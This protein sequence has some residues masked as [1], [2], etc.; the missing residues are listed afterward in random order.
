MYGYIYKTT[1]LINGKIY[2]GQHKSKVFDTKY[3]GSGTIIINAINKY[4]I[5]NFKC[6]LIEECDSYENLNEKECYWIEK[7]NCRNP[8]IGYNLRFG[9]I[10]SKVDERTKEKIH[11]NSLINPNYGMRG[12]QQSE[13]CKEINRKN[14]IGVSPINKGKKMS[15]EQKIKLSLSHIGQKAWNKGVPMRDESKEKLRAIKL[16]SKWMNNGKIEKLIYNTSLVEEWT[17]EVQ[18]RN[19]FYRI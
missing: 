11:N 6:E 7:L 13:L 16:N 4:G 8:E 1:N 5:E 2:I 18:H 10:Q 17:Y 19:R 12:K 9:G 15:E 14:H 3:V